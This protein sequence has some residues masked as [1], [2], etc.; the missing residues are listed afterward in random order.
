MTTT[1]V[2]ATRS[3]TRRDFFVDV[4]STTAT[5][6]A[7]V[8]TVAGLTA[9]VAAPVPVCMAQEI[10]IAAA[11]TVV[12]DN[13]AHQHDDPVIVT[14]IVTFHLS[15]ARGPSK[16]LRIEVFGDSSDEAQFFTSLAAGTVQASCPPEQPENSPEENTVMSMID[17]NAELPFKCTDSES[18]PVSYKGSQLWRLVPDKRLDF[19]RVDSMFASRIP[20]TFSSSSSSALSSKSTQ[21]VRM[22]P[23]TKGAVSMKRNGGAFEF[24][25]TPS[26]NPALDS[27][28][29]DLIVIGRVMMTKEKEEG[30]DDDK[31]SD[32][33]D[34]SSMD[35]VTMLNTKIPT[36][37]D[38]SDRKGIN[39]PPL[40]S[41]FARACNFSEPNTT[42]AQFKP[43]GRIVVTE[44]SVKKSSTQNQQLR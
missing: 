44:V 21:T 35:F 4:A 17:E 11:A 22:A 36:R 25:I 6:T 9:A 14:S 26:Y 37:K 28:K 33:S 19:G 8:V 32:A 13:N 5:T 23:S 10:E 12:D 15:I 40:G 3:N 34:V 2:A 38:L 31:S 43:I 1:T 39:V 30:N 7:G 16:P 29:E 27:E 41:T 20:P 18:V 24:T 42:C